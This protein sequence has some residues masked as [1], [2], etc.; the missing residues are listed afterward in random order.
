LI[1]CPWNAVPAANQKEFAACEFV[2]LR[3]ECDAALRD[4][5][6]KKI[7]V[8]LWNYSAGRRDMT[9]PGSRNLLLIH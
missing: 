7:V 4:R 6:N 9:L 5:R 3:F 1:S 2:R 8:V